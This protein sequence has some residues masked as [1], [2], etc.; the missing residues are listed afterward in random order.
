M[1]S[2]FYIEGNSLYIRFLKNTPVLVQANIVSAVLLDTHQVYYVYTE[3]KMGHYKSAKAIINGT[4]F[5][6]AECD[7]FETC[8]HYSYI[9]DKHQK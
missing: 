7:E 2:H 1:K 4:S 3:D 9:L 8:S 6:I 5:R